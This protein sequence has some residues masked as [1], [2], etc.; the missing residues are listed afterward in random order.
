METP[1]INENCEAR[2]TTKQASEFMSECLADEFKKRDLDVPILDLVSLLHELPTRPEP[3]ATPADNNI[4]AT[5]L[6]PETYCESKVG[7]QLF[8]ILF[9]RLLLF[10]TARSR[11]KGRGF[12][13]VV[14]PIELSWDY[15]EIN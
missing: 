9:I 6:A 15:G 3:D 14:D 11:P 5:V 13:M 2:M 12:G 8:K 4:A 7:G 1:I 10:P